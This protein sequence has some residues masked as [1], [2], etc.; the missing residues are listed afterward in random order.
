VPVGFGALLVVSILA[1]SVSERQVWH[2]YAVFQENLYGAIMAVVPEDT[3]AA[4]FIIIDPQHMI[5]RDV[6]TAIPEV[7]NQTVNL[8]IPGSQLSIHCN[9]PIEALPIDDGVTPLPY[10]ACVRGDGTVRSFLGTVQVA[11]STVIEIRFVGDGP[12]W[13]GDPVDLPWHRARAMLGC[14][15]EGT[16]DHGPNGVQARIVGSADDEAVPS[17]P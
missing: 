14:V 10:G 11:D 6:Y 13:T 4:T 16:C 2:Q 3:E 15:A 12:G 1:G 8:M 9:Q 5:A 17:E 7:L